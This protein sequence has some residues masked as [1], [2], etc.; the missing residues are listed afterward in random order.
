[1]NLKKSPLV[2]VVPNTEAKG[3]EFKDRSI[4]LAETYQQAL[5][6]AGAIPMI[7]A[8]VTSREFIAESI[9]RADGVL[10][11]GGDDVDP[12]L[13]TRKLP[14][15]VMKTVAVVPGDRDLRELMVVDE[16]FRQKKPLMG[17]CRGHQIINV[18]LGGTLI[19]DIELQMNGAINHRRMD[20]KNETVHE[21]RLTEGSLLASITG[22]RTLGV[23]S[24][25]HQALGKVSKMLRVTASSED[26]VVEGTELGNEYSRLL[27]FFVTVQFHPERLASRHPEHQ[28]LFNHFVRACS[29]N[30]KSKI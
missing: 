8:G 30:R 29:K 19:A 11:T 6:N 22:R 14:P 17:I 16:V 2:L 10:L 1:L 21:A 4:S 27:P 23:N 5:F 13:Y 28:A 12:K 18:A 20:L 15:E 25:H 7:L 9:R 3:D 26:G 24:T